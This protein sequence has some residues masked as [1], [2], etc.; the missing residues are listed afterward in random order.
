MEIVNRVVGSV[1]TNCY[2]LMNQG[3]AI[4]FDPGAP[5]SDLDTILSEHNCVLDAI[6]LTHAHFDHIAGIESIIQKY[7]VNVYVHPKEFDFFMDTNLNVSKAFMQPLCVSCQKKALIEGKQKIG[8]FDFE[9]IYTPGHSIGSVVFLYED[10][11]FSGDTLFMGSIGRT[12]M[13]TGSYSDILASL[14]KLKSLQKNYYVLPGHGAQSCLDDEKKWNDF[15][16]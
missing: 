9:I 11:M 6:C 2:I 1:G 16:R 3:H 4:I 8:T 10:I 13:V 14:K 12:D 5:I 15:L 7:P